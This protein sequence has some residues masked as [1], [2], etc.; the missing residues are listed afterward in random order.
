[1]ERDSFEQIKRALRSKGITAGGGEGSRTK[2]Y[3]PQ[4]ENVGNETLRAWLGYWKNA[5]RVA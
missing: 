2:F 4:F 5:S 1:V 3:D